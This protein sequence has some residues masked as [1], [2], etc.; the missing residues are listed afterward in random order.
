MN[1]RFPWLKFLAGIV[2]FTLWHQLY[3]LYPCTLAAIVAEGEPECIFAHQKMLFYPYILLSIVDYVL[4]RRKGIVPGSFLYA[5]LLI[6]VSAPWLMISIWYVPEALGIQMGPTVELIYSILI[7]FLGVYIEIQME[8]PL[9]ATRYG[10]A[11]KILLWVLFVAALIL[12]TGFSFHPP[13]HGL[14]VS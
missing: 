9:E 12:Y 1:R 8:K 10:L 6:L 13:Y 5:R 11:I 2:L 3:D 4:L 7:S 14:F